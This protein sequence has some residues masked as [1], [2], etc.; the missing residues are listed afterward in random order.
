MTAA[1]HVERPSLHR[2][3]LA[4]T[5]HRKSFGAAPKKKRKTEPRASRLLTH[6]RRAAQPPAAPHTPAPP[7]PVPRTGSRLATQA[8]THPLPQR[9]SP[10]P[11]PSPF[12]SGHLQYWPGTS[13]PPQPHTPRSPQRRGS[14]PTACTSGSNAS[15]APPTVLA[16]TAPSVPRGHRRP[17]RR[18]TTKTAPLP[19]DMRGLREADARFAMAT[20]ACT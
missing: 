1:P 5:H 15:P 2:R 14:P 12:H 8:S 17:C 10:L 20:A 9:D 16:Q 7:P 19:D 18:G 6:R 3:T 4:D 11:I 13:N